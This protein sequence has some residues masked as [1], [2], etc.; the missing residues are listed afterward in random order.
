ME[1]GIILR[2]QHVGLIAFIVVG[3]RNEG[4]AL[5]PGNCHGVRSCLSWLLH[6]GVS[7]RL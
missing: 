6:F 7:T 1:V 4:V 3:L 2:A 5:L